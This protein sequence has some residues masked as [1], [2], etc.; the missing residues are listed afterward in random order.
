MENELEL[1][2][3]QIKRFEKLW[4]IYGNHGKKSTHLN[5]KLVQ[6]FYQ[7]RENRIEVYRDGNKNYTDKYGEDYTKEHGVT[8]ECIAACEEIL[9]NP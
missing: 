6:G 8:E 1:T 7:Y 3:S 5:H 2:E 4:F 9:N